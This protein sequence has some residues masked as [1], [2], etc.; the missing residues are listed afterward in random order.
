MNG[1]QIIIAIC[2]VLLTSILG[3]LAFRSRLKYEDLGKLQ[4]KVVI[5]YTRDKCYFCDKAKKL[6][7]NLSI[8]Y[9]EVN[10]T[11]TKKREEILSALGKETLPQVFVGEE[12]LGDSE[13]LLS[14]Y[15]NG[16]LSEM[17]Q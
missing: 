4:N 17:I 11:N 12:Y 1:K 13:T 10:L 6:L 8:K 2:T 5:I 3:Y 15:K 14:F 9:E 7:N 16:K